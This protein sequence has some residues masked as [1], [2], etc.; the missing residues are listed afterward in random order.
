MG[1]EKKPSK[2]EILILE[3]RKVQL[4]RLDQVIE[5]LTKKL[6]DLHQKKQKLDLLQSVSLGLYDE[7]DKLSKK[8]GADQVTDLALGQVNDFISDAKRL[9]PE[10]VYVQRCKEF[11]PTGDNPENRDTVVVMRQMR[12]GLERVLPKNSAEITWRIE[13]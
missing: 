8:S 10:D 12:Q 13:P 2:E 4:A 1:R 5:E 6:G 3:K 9:M 11:V 7:L